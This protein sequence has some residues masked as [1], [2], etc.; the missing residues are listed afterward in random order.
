MHLFAEQLVSS[1][2]EASVL[3]LVAITPL[4]SEYARSCASFHCTCSDFPFLSAAEILRRRGCCLYSS[5]S[6][7]VICSTSEMTSSLLGV[8]SRILSNLDMI[9][10][11]D[12]V[13]FKVTLENGIFDGKTKKMASRYDASLAFVSIFEQWWRHLAMLTTISAIN[14]YKI[15]LKIGTIILVFQLAIKGAISEFGFL[16]LILLSHYRFI[17]VMWYLHDNKSIESQ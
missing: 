1:G 12:D 6:T 4:S 8:W 11:R 7:S 9:A 5:P 10:S 14:R 16:M 13:I 3:A 15:L 2:Q 17:E